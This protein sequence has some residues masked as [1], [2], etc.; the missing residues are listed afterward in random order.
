MPDAHRPSEHEFAAWWHQHGAALRLQ[1]T[2]GDAVEVVYRGDWSH[3]TGPDFANAMVLFRGRELRT[4]AIELHL[5]TSGWRTHGHDRDPAYDR[6]ILHLVL[7][8]D[9][10][11]T[12]T[13]TG[14]LVPVAVAPCDPKELEALASERAATWTRFGGECCAEEFARSRPSALVAILH[15]L[16]DRR[17]AGRVARLS[18]AMTLRA[19]AE[20]LWEEVLDGLGYAQNRDPMRALA[21]RLPAGALVNAMNGVPVVDRVAAVRGLLFGVAGFL[22]L[23]P[24]DASFASLQPA[25][26]ADLERSWAGMAGA[27]GALR[28]APTQW[29]RARVRPAN[30]PATRLSTA[31]GLVAASDGDLL[32]VLASRLRGGDDPVD[33]LRE[34]ATEGGGAPLGEDRAVALAANGVIPLL[35]ALAGETGDLELE[36]AASRAWER[37]PAGGENEVTRRARR[38]VSGDVALR[39]LG[40]RGQQG[41]IHLDGTLCAPRRCFECPVAAWVAADPSPERPFPPGTGR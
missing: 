13:A 37:L 14:T 12:R 28:L 27:W 38:Q 7:H 40:M 3:G 39:G 21:E 31:A 22:P 6:V 34:L 25:E 2:T 19:P 5:A 18:G 20:V 32:Q 9:G 35:I 8:D 41:L 33:V 36:D 30:H 29:V 10:A 17:L 4:G 26:V 24:T 15:D 23:A 16:G 1:T 11:E